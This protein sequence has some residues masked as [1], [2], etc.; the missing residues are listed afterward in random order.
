MANKSFDN[1]KI[2]VTFKIVQE[3]GAGEPTPTVTLISGENVAHSLGKI[4]YFMDH[5]EDY[6]D[7]GDTYVF[8]NGD[9]TSGAG[10]WKYTKNGGA[11]TAVH[12]Y[13]VPL[14]DTTTN[15]IPASYLPSYVDDVIEAYYYNGTMYADAAHQTPITGETG[16]IYVDITPGEDNKV[17]RYS[18]SGYIRIAS[19]DI[20]EG[21]TESSDG[22][23]GYVPQPTTSGYEDYP[24]DPEEGIDAVNNEF[25]RG[26]GTWSTAPVIV[27]D[28]LI[29]NCVQD[30]VSP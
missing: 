19:G 1:V 30:T 18:G 25:L 26:D 13:G 27:Q 10:T 4:K 2:N 20:M 21:A 6:I 9:S 29:L 11:A 5:I 15:K 3:P 14:L 17:Y 8:S 12:V 16:K 22:K 24:S 7:T 23:A 28:T